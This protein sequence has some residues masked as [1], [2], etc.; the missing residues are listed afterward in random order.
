MTVRSK[1][2]NA[3]SPAVT[4]QEPT[5]FTGA[6]S[7]ARHGGRRVRRRVRPEDTL[8]QP[9]NSLLGSL[10]CPGVK[11]LLFAAFPGTVQIAVEFLPNFFRRPPQVSDSL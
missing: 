9:L 2:T 4:A 1:V 7:R 8:Q 5:H 10:F 3:T 11:A 6:D